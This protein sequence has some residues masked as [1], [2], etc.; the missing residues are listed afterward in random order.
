MFNDSVI[1]KKQN[2]KLYKAM[3]NSWMQKKIGT[4]YR[5]QIV[6]QLKCFYLFIFFHC[7]FSDCHRIYIQIGKYKRSPQRPTHLHKRKQQQQQRTKKKK[8][9]LCYTYMSSKH[10]CVR[11]WHTFY[12]SLSKR[13]A[14]N[15]HVLITIYAY[16]YGL[17]LYS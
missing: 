2:G 17:Y 3:F 10:I 12:L 8:K 14:T 7:S 9:L 15:T 5:T 1:Q 4:E 11:C 13:A 6:I 16:L